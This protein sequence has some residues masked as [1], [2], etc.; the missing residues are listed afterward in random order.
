MPQH[1]LFWSLAHARVVI[2]DWKDD[3]N[4]RRRHSAL[5]YQPPAVCAASCTH[6]VAHLSGPAT[7]DRQPA[8][9]A[10]PRLPSP[11]GGCSSDKH[12]AA[13]GPLARTL[14]SHEMKDAT[15]LAVGVSSACFEFD[16][17][18]RRYLLCIAGV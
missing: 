13:V 17:G 11:H 2:A 12:L 7:A 4:H 14:A 16:C 3:D 18:R 15:E 1:N 5:C 6:R 8:V 9:V 10:A